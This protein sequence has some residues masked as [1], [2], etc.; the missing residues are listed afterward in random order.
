M[1]LETQFRIRNQSERIKGS[2]TDLHAWIDGINS[3]K[4]EIQEVRKRNQ[5]YALAKKADGNIRFAEGEYEVAIEDY[6]LGIASVAADSEA[7]RSL[8]AQ[9]LLNRALCFYKLLKCVECIRDCKQ[10]YKLKPT[11]KALFRK[12]CAEL[13]L[14]WLD[15]ARTSFTK[16]NDMVPESD[17]AAHQL[18]HS[19][20]E[21]LSTLEERRRQLEAD[22]CRRRLCRQAPQWCFHLAR[23]PLCDL[24]VPGI[25][26]QESE[27]KIVQTPTVLVDKPR[28]IPRAE[29]MYPPKLERT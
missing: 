4:S 20:L 23:E 6:S 18:V 14:A 19:K 16:C 17:I 28:Y 5:D 9:L 21:S 11:S 12:G 29:R 27:Q 13:D 10:A 25:C 22:E 2:L 8:M 15:A 7:S 3:G 26:L 24:N 1:S